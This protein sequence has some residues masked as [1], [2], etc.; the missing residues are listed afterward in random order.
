MFRN[1][2][3]DPI[4]LDNWITREPDYGACHICGKEE[5]CCECPFCEVCIDVKKVNEM[6]HEDVCVDCVKEEIKQRNK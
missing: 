2:T 1:N 3:I 5:G 6:Y 4:E